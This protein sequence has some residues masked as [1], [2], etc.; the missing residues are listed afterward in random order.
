MLRAS[1]FLLV[2]ALPLAAAGP[3]PALYY[4]SG[5]PIQG[6]GLAPEAP[7]GNESSLAVVTSGAD[8]PS[9]RF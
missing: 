9:D 4:L 3:A 1:V 5:D 7:S 8:G 2:L 6:Q